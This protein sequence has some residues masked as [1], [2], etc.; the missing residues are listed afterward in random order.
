MF[1]FFLS[2]CNLF[3]T[4]PSILAFLCSIESVLFDSV[5]PWTIA[6]QVLCTQDFP[7]RYTVVGC[8]AL[9]QEIFSIQG[10]NPGL[11]SL[12]HCRRILYCW[13]PGE[14]HLYFSVEL[15]HSVMSNSLRPHGLQH[16]GFPSPSPIPRARSNS[17]PTNQRC[18]PTISFSVVTFSSCIQAC[19]ASGYFPMSQFFPSSGQ[20]IGASALA[21]VLPMNIQDWF[22]L[23]LIDLLVF[24]GTPKSLLQHHS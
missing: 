17:G 2:V 18:H 5:T 23:G 21:S 10:L 7:I 14:A 12:L 19:P 1:F 15:Y 4:Y 22:P 20:S 24:P 9:L 16:A 13:A 6:Q 11:L 8:H 3:F